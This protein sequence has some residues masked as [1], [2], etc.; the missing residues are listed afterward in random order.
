[1]L[2]MPICAMS[3]VCEFQNPIGSLKSW[4]KKSNR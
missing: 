3:N 1:M 2:L 4:K